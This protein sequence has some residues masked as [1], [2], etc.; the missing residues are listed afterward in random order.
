MTIKEFESIQSFGQSSRIEVQDY[1]KATIHRYL[2]PLKNETR[3][4]NAYNFKYSI[5]FM[6][7]G[8]EYIDQ[9]VEYASLTDLKSSF[10]SLFNIRNKQTKEQMKER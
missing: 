10:I 8:K 3:K 6:Y 2:K 4:H 7:N 9:S 1:A 5:L